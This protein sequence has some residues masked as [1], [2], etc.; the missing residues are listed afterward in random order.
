ME[1]RTT[2]L[3]LLGTLGAFA[4]V[5]LLWLFLG[6]EGPGP[7]QTATAPATA[8]GEAARA[9]RGA[10]SA[11]DRHTPTTRWVVVFNVGKKF[12]GVD[13]TATINGRTMAA[14]SPNSDGVLKVSTPFDPVVEALETARFTGRLADGFFEVTVGPEAF[15]NTRSEGGVIDLR[16]L[17]EEAR[18]R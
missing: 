15:V 9:T 18:P 5:G 4:G 2:T 14:G 7:E 17:F 6:T 16:E 13:L 1:T 8:I 12:E 3:A 10:P 11:A